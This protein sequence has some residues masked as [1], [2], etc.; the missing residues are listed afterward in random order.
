MTNKDMVKKAFEEVEEE[1][2]Q[3]EIKVL[4]RQIQRVLEATELKKKQKALVEEELR[5]LKEDLEDLK[6]GNIVAIKERQDKSKIAR[7]VSPVEIVII[8]Q[9]IYKEIVKREPNYYHGTYNLNLPDCIGTTN[10]A[11]SI[12]PGFTASSSGTNMINYMINKYL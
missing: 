7:N 5:I 10:S 11:S 9:P 3:K 1:L 12:T 2:N 8:N 4:K 6:N